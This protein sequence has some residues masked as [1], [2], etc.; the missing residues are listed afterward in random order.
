MIDSIFVLGLPQSMI[1]G[2][3]AVCTLAVVIPV[4]M[5]EGFYSGSV[6][7][8]GVDSLGALVQEMFRVVIYGPQPRGSLD[9]LRIAP[10]PFKPNS[11]PS[12]DAIHFQG[13]T[14][15]ATIRIYDLAG[16][17]VFGPET[18]SDG[19][20]HI[21]WDAEVASGIYIYLVTASDGE[22]KKGRLSVIR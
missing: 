22:M 3:I 15:D 10:I 2:Q 7:I 14:N 21:A 18:D 4:N 11:E 9:S 5:T 19:D 20:G 12:H 17:L 6:T 1:V 16:T 13:L 8:E